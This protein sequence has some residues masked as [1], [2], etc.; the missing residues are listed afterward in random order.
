MI[1]IIDHLVED[2][3]RR[4]YTVFQGSYKIEAQLIG[5]V[6][7]PPLKRTINDIKQSNTQFFGFF[8]NEIL[9][10]VI[11]ISIEENELHIC[12]LTVAPEFFR[13]G[14]ASQ[15]IDY[16]LKSIKFSKATVET[17]VVNLPAVKL[18]EKHG[19]VEFKK[20]TPSH[21]IR[22]IALSIG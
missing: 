14:I 4:I 18:Y 1:N 20:W 12:S 21:G 3:A 13:K 22:K 15:L 17:A 6:D 9:A 16:V 2:N 5:V 7:F 11:E 8:E 19:F 10:A